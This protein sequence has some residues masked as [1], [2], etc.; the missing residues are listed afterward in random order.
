M[1]GATADI[2]VAGGITLDNVVT[3]DGAVHVEQIG[4]NGIYGTIGARLWSDAAV[5]LAAVPAAFAEDVRRRVAGAGLDTRGVLAVDREVPELE[6]L[7][8]DA[9]GN[10][11]DYVFATRDDAKAAGMYGSPS[12][13]AVAKWRQRLAS[14]SA[15]AATYPD[16]IRDTASELTPLLR[17]L[18]VPRGLHLAPMEPEWQIEA[19]RWARS[20]GARVTLDPGSRAARIARTPGLL[21]EILASVDVFL[22]SRR[23]LEVLSTT[24]DPRS[25][26]KALASRGTADV[27]V[28]L[29]DEGVLLWDR[30]TAETIHVPAFSV[31]V[32][33]PTGA[34]DAFC[35][36]FI[37]GLVAT[38]DLTEAARCGVVSASFVVETFGGL[39]AAAADRAE[40][41]RRRAALQAVSSR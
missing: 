3:A 36:G 34:G 29:G 10:R 27:G 14:R 20:A 31:P 41:L 13:D 24:A 19:A 21:D 18:P 32:R 35:G 38:G 23:E 28:K 16:F 39:G 2:I 9:S 6:W 17:A 5:M 22:P 37:A 12:A 15:S 1:N 26:L 7:F 30:A 11:L 33:D 4:G 25:G 8:Y 40:A